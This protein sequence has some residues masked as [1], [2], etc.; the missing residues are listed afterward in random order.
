[1]ENW[2]EILAGM[3]EGAAMLL[4]ASAAWIAL[5]GG[6]VLLLAAAIDGAIIALHG[7]A[8]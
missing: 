3:A 4:V 6:I 7:A 5:G 2:K 8:Q 1:M